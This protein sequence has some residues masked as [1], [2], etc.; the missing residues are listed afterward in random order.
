MK[1]EGVSS[2]LDTDKGIRFQGRI[3]NRASF[4][5][6]IDTLGAGKDTLKIVGESS[7]MESAVSN[8]L[9]AALRISNR[10]EDGKCD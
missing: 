8:T 9:N 5:K 2:R 4:R 7:I 1:S 6:G 10:I 3:W